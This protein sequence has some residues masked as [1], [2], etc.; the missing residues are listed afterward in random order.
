M[1]YQPEELIAWASAVSTLRPGDVFSTGSGP[2]NG[3]MSG[4]WLQA[5]DVIEAK[6]AGLGRQK[7][8][9]VAERQK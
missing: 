5:G 4:R 3:M 2:G 1:I 8:P 7:T 9:V 6:I